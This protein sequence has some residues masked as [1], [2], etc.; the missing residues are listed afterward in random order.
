MTRAAVVYT[1]GQPIEVVDV[2]HGT[3]RD[4]DVLV[5]MKASGLCHTDV[6]VQTGAMPMP[7][8]IILGHEGSGVVEQVGSAVRAVRP[9]DHVVFNGIISCGQCRTCQHGRPNLCEWGLPTI[10]GARQPDGDLRARDRNGTELHQFVC[11]GTLAEQAIVPELAALP[12]PPDVPFEVA[13][14]IGCGVLTGV[15]AVFN[16]ARVRP[17]S[18]VAVIG[19]GGVGLNVIQA[20]RLVGATTLVGIDPAAMK[21]DLAREFGATHAIDPSTENVVDRVL[22]LTDGRGVDYAFECVG[23]GDL[24][25]QAWDVIASDGTVVTIG[26]PPEGAT[27]ELP[28]EAFWSTEKTLMCSLYGSGNPR[29]DIPLYIELYRQGRLKVQELVTR[30]YRLSQINEAVEALEASRNARG[31]FIF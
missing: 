2:V 13:A 3:L 7:T 21:R 28:G 11:L 4:H 22:E 30:R 5:R 8:P 26:V 27:A 10:L 25:R 1:S 18:T 16:R 31:V 29:I 6:S 12:I 20:A 19:C 14:L 24:V 23:R 15:G 9:G 17:G